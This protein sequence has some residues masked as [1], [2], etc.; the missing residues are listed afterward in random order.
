MMISAMLAIRIDE[1]T[2]FGP[3]FGPSFMTSAND[4]IICFMVESNL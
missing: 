2:G 4:R 3:F 1:Q